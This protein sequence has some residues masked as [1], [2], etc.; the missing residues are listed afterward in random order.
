MGVASTRSD[1]L[2]RFH[3]GDRK[4]IEGIY[5]EH[6]TTVSRAVG[7]T[8]GPADRETVIHEIFLRLL[9]QPFLRCS[10]QGGDL[11]AWLSVVSRNHAMDCARRRRRE[12]PA[13]ATAAADR[14][15]PDSGEAGIEARLLIERFRREALP[16]CWAPVFDARFIRQLSQEE[17]AAALGMGRTTLAYQEARLRRLLRRFVLKGGRC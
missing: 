12:V 11:A 3:D 16:P 17:A 7:T 13:S 15:C 8:A 9:S 2:R 1:W 5:R 6:F 10:F 4:I 14:P